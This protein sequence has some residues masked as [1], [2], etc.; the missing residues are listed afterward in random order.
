VATKG[1]KTVEKK[2]CIS[3]A[4]EIDAS[5]SK[6]PFCKIVQDT[7]ACTVCSRAIPKNASRCNACSS[8]QRPWQRIFTTSKEAFGWLT[9]LFAVIGNLVL[10]IA[11]VLENQSSTSYAVV[12]AN[13]ENIYVDVWN[14]GKR[15]SRLV[16]Y[17]LTFK[18]DDRLIEK[19]TLALMPVDEAAGRREQVAIIAESQ[20][21]RISMRPIARLKMRCS[22]YDNK[23]IEDIR[24]QLV[25][26]TLR[27]EITIEES[28]FL[29]YMGRAPSGRTQSKEVS[30]VLLKDFLT[31]VC[32]DATQEQSP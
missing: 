6:C 18:D 9:A 3:C 29:S 12:D 10:G 30:G 24:K 1:S 23:C 16:G 7:K 31:G 21:R 19:N 5:A 32:C 17:R 28:G 22:K 8:Y 27:L 26:Q 25:Q 2:K 15:S 14:T 4:E 11:Y 13:L 20:T